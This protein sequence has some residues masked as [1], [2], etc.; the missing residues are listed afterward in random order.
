MSAPHPNARRSSMKLSDLLG[1]TPAPAPTPAAAMPPAAA[2]K[3]AAPTATHPAPTHQAPQA[4]RAP[5]TT[6]ASQASHTPRAGTPPAVKQEDWGPGPHERHQARSAEPSAP[7][8]V[9][10]ASASSA[11]PRRGPSGS[12]SGLL[13]QILELLR[14]HRASDFLVKEGQPLWFRADGSLRVSGYP[15]VT[16]HD[17]KELVRPVLAT[18]GE[19]GEPV[20]WLQDKGDCDFALDFGRG[21]RFRA[22]LFW[23]ENQHLAM[24]LRALPEEVPPMEGLGLPA[25]FKDLLGQSKGLLLV[26]GATGSGKTTTLASGINYLNHTM[27][28]HIITMED[29]VEYR[30][31]SH[32][33]LVNQ[34]QVGRDA[35]TFAAGLRSAL[36]QDPDVLLIGELRDHETVKTALDAA[37][38]GHLVLGTLHT[39][40]AQQTIERVTSFFSDEQKGWAQAVLAQT[41][42][43]VIS[44]VLVPKIGGGRVLCAE[45]LVNTPD[46]RQLIR[47]GRTHQIFNSM[48]TGTAKGHV[49]LNRVLKERVREGL[50]DAQDALCATYDPAGLTKEMAALAPVNETENAQGSGKRGW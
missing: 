43:G 35:K 37:N 31:E 17:I 19:D 1:S 42:L 32:R 6:P 45:L 21:A 30:I 14:Q 4:P 38:T 39:N 20:H 2:P 16:A 26:T 12:T 36:R 13:P 7:A 33:C 18:G 22:N 49:L 23:S 29:P 11:T 3:P 10:S 9:T 40:S 50:V 27:Q 25:T 28:G 5:Q 15:A 47:E 34:R 41:L 46:V 8:A 44:Q 48:D 24:A